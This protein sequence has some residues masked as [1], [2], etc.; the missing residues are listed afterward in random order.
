[1]TLTSP[2]LEF[3]LPDASIAGE[4]AEVRGSG[5]DDVRLMVTH[6]MAGSIEHDRFTNIT[7][8]LR[9]GD[10]LVVNSSATIPASIMASTHD[11]A[12]VRVHF[13]SPAIG[14][15][16]QVEVR[17][18]LPDGATAPGPDLAPQTLELSGGAI[19]HLL[20]RSPQTPRLWVAA[21]AGATGAV[22]HLH[23]HGEPVRYTPGPTLPIESYQTVFAIHPGSAEMPSAARPFTSDMVTRLVSK[24]IAV[25][26]IVLHT[27]VSSYESDETPGEERYEVPAATAAVIN[28][29]RD[30]GGRAIA[31]GTTVLRALETVVDGNGTIHPGKGVTDVVIGPGHPLTSVDGMITGWHEPRSS[32]LGLLEAVLPRPLLRDVYDEAINGGYLWHEFGDLLLILP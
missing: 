13:A 28:A 14:G 21:F 23:L 12:P 9:P 15:L 30:N 26:P 5:R 24:G 3:A 2:P 20:A 8:H 10:V 1:M 32:H 6:R 19:L 17:T 7:R 22:D 4:P 31:V 11:G 27:G 25:V 18:A 29:L 16:W